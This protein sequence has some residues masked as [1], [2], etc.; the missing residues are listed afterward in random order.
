M[1]SRCARA[2]GE[3]P[4]RHGKDED[5]FETRKC[6]LLMEYYRLKRE[7]LS[8]TRLLFANAA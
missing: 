2:W 3:E 1:K 7:I 4:D 5:Y 6:G 8:F